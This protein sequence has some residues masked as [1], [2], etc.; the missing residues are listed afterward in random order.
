VPS[1]VSSVD[2]QPAINR[3]LLFHAAKNGITEAMF[4]V[5]GV[6]E[7]NVAD[8]VCYSYPGTRAHQ[9]RRPRFPSRPRALVCRLK[10]RWG[11]HVLTAPPTWLVGVT[12]TRHFAV[13]RTSSSPHPALHVADY[14]C[15]H[16]CD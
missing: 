9:L 12:S 10:S 8:Q 13:C 5:L 16:N 7:V 4:T 2:I 11:E 15:R 3:G 14:R 1:A 6:C